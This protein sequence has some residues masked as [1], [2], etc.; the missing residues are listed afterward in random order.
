MP[1]LRDGTV[2]QR[3]YA[4]DDQKAN[5]SALAKY[6]EMRAADDGV[7]LSRPEPIRGKLTRAFY[8]RCLSCV[9]ERTSFPASEFDSISKIKVTK[10]LL[11][12]HWAQTGDGW[13]C[14]ECS[15]VLEKTS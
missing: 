13:Y 2:S 7:L 3:T 4:G 9:I 6:A 14:P 11:E 1:L 15:Q 8:V 12:D 10:I 5:P